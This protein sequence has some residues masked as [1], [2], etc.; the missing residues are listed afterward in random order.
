[1]FLA[2]AVDTWFPAPGAPVVLGVHDA[3]AAELPRLV[4]PSRR[5]RALWRL[6]QGLALRSAARMF[7]PSESARA[8]IVRHMGVPADRLAVIPWAPDPVFAPPSAGAA[9]A[10]RRRVGLAPDEPYLVYGAGINP[11]K[12]LGTLLEAYAGLEGRPRLVLAGALE[13]AYVS[14]AAA[15][16]DQ[17]AALGLEG[18][19][20]LPGFVPDETLAALYG[21]ALGAVVPSQAEGFGLP[22]VEAAACGAPTVLSD[23]GA[24]RETLGE[25]SL[26]FAPGDAGALR[27]Q[28]GRLAAEPD[29]RRR[30]GEDGRRAVS[31]LSWDAA[32]GRLH[33]LLRD[34]AEHHALPGRG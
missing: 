20:L 30:L 2:P 4:L 13:G 33:D 32:A 6:K 7:T 14:A 12:G 11:H 21:G 8:A 22:A 5:A 31:A 9:G 27:A 10:A 28:L 29:L 34:A 24:H 25:H 3:T 18:E 16:R 15:L 1:M 19:V 23:I 17:V 26:L